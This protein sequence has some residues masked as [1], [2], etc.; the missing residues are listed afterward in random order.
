MLLIFTIPL[1]LT[2]N[3]HYPQF[4]QVKLKQEGELTSS[5]TPG[6]SGGRIIIKLISMTWLQ[7]TTLHCCSEIFGA[8]QA[9]VHREFILASQW[10]SL[11]R[12]RQ[13]LNF[14]A[15]SLNSVFNH[16]TL[17]IFLHSLPKVRDSQPEWSDSHKKKSL[18]LFDPTLR[19]S[20]KV[21]AVSQ[22]VAI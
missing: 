8:F 7:S 20:T 3:C 17:L 11:P 13:S 1:R 4:A 2:G 18:L 21:H 16:E 9:S 14:S 10:K 6:K 15:R 5:T 12:D 22:S 19:G